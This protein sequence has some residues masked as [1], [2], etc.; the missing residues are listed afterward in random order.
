MSDAQDVVTERPADLPDSEWLRVIAHKLDVICMILLDLRRDIREGFQ[1]YPE[2]DMEV[3]VDAPLPTQAQRQQQGDDQ[4]IND[5]N[6]MYVRRPL[7]GKHWLMLTINSQTSNI[8]QMRVELPN[9]ERFPITAAELQETFGI[10]VN[11][12]FSEP[13]DRT[14]DSLNPDVET[15]DERP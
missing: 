7:P 13:T 6:L 10:N 5:G 1:P 3:D 4:I 11:T 8:E 2:P 9:G 12:T 15:P 14:A